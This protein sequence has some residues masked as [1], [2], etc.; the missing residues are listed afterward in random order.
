[1]RVE[2]GEAA[3]FGTHGVWAE[4]EAFT[5]DEAR[6]VEELGLGAIWLGGSPRSL[7]RV[8]E[9][10]AATARITVATGIVNI[11]NTDPASIAAEFLA[12][13]EDFPGR[14]YL[15]VGAGHPERSAEYRAPYEE[16]VRYL[17][18]LDACGVPV[19]RRL[20][21][22]LGP[23]MLRLSAERSL[24][25]HPY[26]VPAAYTGAAREA[27]GLGALL[28]PE[29]KAVVEPD[30][31]EARGIA[32]GRV[33]AYLRLGNYVANLRRL[34]YTTADLEGEGSDRLV[35]DLVAHGDASTVRARL[36]AH[37]DAGADH[38]AIQA[39]G[40]SGRLAQ[41]AAIMSARH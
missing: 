40:A 32:R 20:L 34:G 1:M 30:P 6:A 21:A 13:E 29:H 26:L 28:A 19:T 33:A 18:V 9:V 17:D 12:L 27:V 38:V 41:L 35:D 31:S 25:A 5:P 36:D 23:R 2:P 14:F 24:G 22:A 4:V 7:V 16:V 3:R 8:R 15:G 11:W 37:L 39:L 10:L